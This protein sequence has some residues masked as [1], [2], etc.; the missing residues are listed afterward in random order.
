MRIMT[1]NIHGCVGTDGRRSPDRIADA[2]GAV[3][4]DI[5]AL[6]EVDIRGEG[7][8]PR[9]FFDL[10][11]AHVGAHRHEVWTITDRIRRYGIALVSRW[12]IRSAA[13]VDLAYRSR[14]PR[15][16]IDA[17]VETPDGPVRVVT[18]HLGLSR[19][20]RLEQMTRLGD[21]LGRIDGPAIALGDFNDWRDPGQVGRMLR[22]AFPHVFSGRTFPSRFPV[23]PLDRIFLTREFRAIR[24]SVTLQSAASD[25]LPV[26]VDADLSSP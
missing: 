22:P 20:E 14:E 21:A 7:L 18:T 3:Q 5:L 10:I 1:W 23:F 19:P 25:H 4:P 8:D 12:P 15:T 13:A 6:Q 9:S 24:A 16:A 17:K 11:E 2:I 26:I